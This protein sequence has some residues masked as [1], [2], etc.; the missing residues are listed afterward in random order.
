MASKYYPPVGHSNLL[1][2][3]FMAVEYFAKY[4][5]EL[6][7]NSVTVLAINLVKDACELEGRAF[8]FHRTPKR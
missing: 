6:V 4:W 5:R 1:L 2:S 3:V 7:T 8:R